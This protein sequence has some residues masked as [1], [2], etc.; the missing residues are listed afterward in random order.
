MKLLNGKD[1]WV[2][3]KSPGGVPGLFY[4]YWFY[5]SEWGGIDRRFPA[6]FFLGLTVCFVFVARIGRLWW[7][8]TG[9]GPTSGS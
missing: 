7:G 9:F 5:F 1:L 3:R 2:E 6:D 8:L 4:L